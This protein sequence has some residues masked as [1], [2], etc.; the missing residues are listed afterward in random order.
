VPDLR[1]PQPRRFDGTT[2]S[3][4]V[5]E[6]EVVLETIEGE[7]LRFETA[8]LARERGDRAERLTCGVFVERAG[9]TEAYELVAGGLH[10][11]WRFTLPP[12]GTGAL[13][14]R[15][16]VARAEEAPDGAPGFRLRT[17]TAAFRSWPAGAAAC[18]S[19]QGVLV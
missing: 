4:Y 10:Q 17:A 15:V 19:A 18:E 13:L 1:S 3:A 6:R 5:D 9:C 14:V 7:A 8:Q 2:W 12:S 11:H 16:P